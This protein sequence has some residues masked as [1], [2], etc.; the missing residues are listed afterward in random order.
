MVDR[1][2]PRSATP[3]TRE[4]VIQGLRVELPARRQVGRSRSWIGLLT[5]VIE[6]SY[7]RPR[8][9]VITEG[10][11]L[12]RLDTWALADV[13]LLPRNRQLVAMG[14]G[15]TPPRGYPLINTEPGQ[16]KRT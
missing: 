7:P 13:I 2:P 6:T 12:G 5:G 10:L 4:W 3:L 14:G 1:K 16:I 8:V 9:E 11:S 15:F